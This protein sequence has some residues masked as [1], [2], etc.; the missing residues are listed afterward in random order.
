MR[1]HALVD[2]YVPARLGSLR[3]LQE[4]ARDAGLD[5]FVYAVEE[6]A[7][8]PSIE[9]F[10]ALDPLGPVVVIA[11]TITGMGFRFA[12]LV[13]S[14]LAL[15]VEAVESQGDPI[16]VQTALASMGGLAL[17]VAPR[18]AAPGVVGRSATVLSGPNRCGVV[19]LAIPGSR[20]GRDLDLEDT[21]LSERPIL[22]ASGP[23]ATVRDIG[24]YATL[25]PFPFR[26]AQH[27]AADQQRL[28]AALASGVG[29]AVEQILP[30]PRPGALPDPRE[31]RDDERGDRRKRPR[32][33]RRK[34]RGEPREGSP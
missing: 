20:L 23:F 32:R 19:A 15:D 9:D 13:P 22:G 5:G 3:D 2:L 33:R 16:L 8:V 25:L 11:A 27:L 18:Q 21:V 10:E 14:H 28:I 4:A 7:D 29:V 17:P 1:S 31:G 34:G 26:G 24:R 12:C 6:A 30:E